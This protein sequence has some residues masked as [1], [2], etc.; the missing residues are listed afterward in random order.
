MRIHDPWRARLVDSL[1]HQMVLVAQVQAILRTPNN[2][3]YK[4]RSS[5]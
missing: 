2:G 5:I 1:V 3:G 4:N